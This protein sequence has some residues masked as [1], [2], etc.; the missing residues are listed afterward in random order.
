MKRRCGVVGSLWASCWLKAV[1]TVDKMWAW[2]L[3][4]LYVDSL[5]VICC[6]CPHKLSTFS[7][8]YISTGAPNIEFLAERLL[9]LELDTCWCYPCPCLTRKPLLRGRI[10]PIQ[11]Q[12][13]RTTLIGYSVAPECRLN[14]LTDGTDMDHSRRM[15]AIFSDFW[16]PSLLVSFMILLL[17]LFCLP[18]GYPPLPF[19]HA[20]RRHM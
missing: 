1:K 15:F 10:L 16:I 9:L 20:L 17:P 3:C 13:M 4:G 6:F 11:C 7:L 19:L 2:A 8:S 12:Q 14:R 5:W 18:C